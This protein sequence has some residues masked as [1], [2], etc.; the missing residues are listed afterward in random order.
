LPLANLVLVSSTAV[1]D[2]VVNQ[3]AMQFFAK[4]DDEISLAARVVSSSS[5]RRATAR[6]PARRAPDAARRRVAVPARRLGRGRD[7]AEEQVRP[8]LE[9]RV[10]ATQQGARP[11]A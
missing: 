8:W 11:F 9:P 7:R 6:A 10:L 3:V 2:L 1:A 4:V 5:C